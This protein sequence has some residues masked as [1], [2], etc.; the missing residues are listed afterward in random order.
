M[1]R[2]IPSNIRQCYELNKFTFTDA[3]NTARST[4]MQCIRDKIN[5]GKTIVENAVNNIQSA[6]QDMSNGSQLIS[7]CQQYLSSF[8][9]SAG[10]VA[11]VACL[12]QVY[13]FYLEFS[14]FFH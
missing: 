1:Q 10:V 2:S 13:S 4:A 9:S 14:F 12:T 8:P 11:K 5:Q 7:Q 3:M 6:A